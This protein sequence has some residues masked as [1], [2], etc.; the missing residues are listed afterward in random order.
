VDETVS[1]SYPIAGVGIGSH[2]R[3]PESFNC[4]KKRG[5]P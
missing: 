3:F 1:R 2:V 4:G 5:N